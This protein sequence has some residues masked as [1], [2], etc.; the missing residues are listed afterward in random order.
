MNPA[1]LFSLRKPCPDCPFLKKNE[2][3]LNPGR[4]EGFIRSLHDNRPFMCHKTV[5]YSKTAHKKQIENARYCAGS[6]VYLEKAGNPNVPMRL[7]R[8]FG[9]YDPSQLSGHEDVIEP[10]GLDR[11]ER[12]SGNNTPHISRT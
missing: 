2:G 7:G 12:I 3:M 11:Y 4:L 10:M 1:E 8:M 9:Y 6:M 5:D